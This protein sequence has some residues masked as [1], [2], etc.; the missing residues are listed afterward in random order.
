MGQLQFSIRCKST[1]LGQ[2]VAVVGEGA[3]LHDWGKA[4]AGGPLV[5]SCVDISGEVI[6]PMWRSSQ[7]LQVVLGQRLE[8]KYVLI[9]QEDLH[10]LHWETEGEGENR[11][12]VVG[13]GELRGEVVDDG[14]FGRILA[15]RGSRSSREPRRKSPRDERHAHKSAE[16]TAGERHAAERHAGA[17]NDGRVPHR[18]EAEQESSASM[19]PHKRLERIGK[20]KQGMCFLAK[21]EDGSEVLLKE[22]KNGGRQAFRAEVESLQNL[23]D[24]MAARIG[25]VPRFLGAAYQSRLVLMTFFRGTTLPDGDLAPALRGPSSGLALALRCWLDVAGVVQEANDL[26]IIHCDVNPWN[27]LVAN[28]TPSSSSDQVAGADGGASSC[29]VDWA[30]AR[31]PSKAARG[32]PFKKRGDFQAQ[33]LL[34]GCVG[35]FT[36]VF[37]CAATLLWF[38]SKRTRKGLAAELQEG[39]AALAKFFLSFASAPEGSLCDAVASSRLPMEQLATACVWGLD[40]SWE[41]RRCLREVRDIVSKALASLEG[42]VAN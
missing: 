34:D 35:P 4:A 22:L 24:T 3:F 9:S 29:L 20:G 16:L 25:S 1:K 5:L 14:D 19:P 27:V 41:S 12:L 38:L 2:V 7:P 15:E 30:C 28:G 26:G 6:W 39:P 17:V 32:L 31:A 23:S 8:Y 33:E 13:A 18:Q 42:V 10:I 36:D 21:L 40:E 37:G 11:R